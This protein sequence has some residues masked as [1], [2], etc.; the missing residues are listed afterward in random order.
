M[1]TKCQSSMTN[2]FLLS[3]I[4]DIIQGGWGERER[5]FVILE[6]FKLSSKEY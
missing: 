1:E 3:E 4:M 5:V 2:Y 6:S